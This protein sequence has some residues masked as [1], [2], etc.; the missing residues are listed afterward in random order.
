VL[1]HRDNLR[2][3]YNLFLDGGISRAHLAFSVG[4]WKY[5]SL[6]EVGT[7][8][9]MFAFLIASLSSCRREPRHWRALFSAT[10]VRAG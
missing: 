8:S 4:K 2:Q 7:A 10:S 6:G 5:L 1:L 3:S 9:P